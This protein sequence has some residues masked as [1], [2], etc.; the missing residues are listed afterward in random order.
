MER[1]TSRLWAH[2]TFKGT[3]RLPGSY[4]ILLFKRLFDCFYAKKMLSSV[5]SCYGIS[6]NG[7][8][9]RN[10]IHHFNVPLLLML[11]ITANTFN[12]PKIVM[13]RQ[14]CFLL[15]LFW[16]MKWIKSLRPQIP[17]HARY[18]FGSEQKYAFVFFCFSP[19]ASST[20]LTQWA[21]SG[22]RLPE[23]VHGIR[24]WNS[25]WPLLSCL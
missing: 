10:I 19:K 15:I 21:D 3:W 24:S 11:S 17:Q 23:A 20:R 18:I 1:L 7:E 2:K 13:N 25:V 6:E 14:V 8:I 9:K 12:Q 4:F 5:W 16:A 22:I